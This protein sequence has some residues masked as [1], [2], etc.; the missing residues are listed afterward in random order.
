VKSTALA[1]QVDPRELA[2]Q[3]A[4]VTGGSEGI[5]AAIVQRL[6]DAGATLAA[7]ARRRP[8]VTAATLFVEADLATAEGVESVVSRVHERLGGVDIIVSNVGGATAPAGGFAVLTDEEWQRAL[9]INLLAAVRLD[10]A[11][12]PG[13]LQRKTGAIVHVTS[14]QDRLPLFESTL[15]YAAAK[16]ALANYSKGLSKEVGPRGIRVNAV[17]PGMIATDAARRLVHRLAEQHGNDERSAREGLMKSLGGIPVGRPGRPE[18]V[19]ELVA[20]LVSPRAAFVHGSELVIDGGTVPT[21]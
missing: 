8:A 4:L 17:A 13:M 14:I 15:A 6:S 12:L 7:T 19:A 3:R 2:G 5:G 21:V 10:R 9:T 16:A 18:E 1:Y 20:F 11:F